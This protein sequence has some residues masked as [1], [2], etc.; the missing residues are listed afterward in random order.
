MMHVGSA[1]AHIFECPNKDCKSTFTK[2]VEINFSTRCDVCKT[3][4]PPIVFMV[5]N[6]AARLDY[7]LENAKREEIFRGEK[8]KRL[9]KAASSLAPLRNTLCQDALGSM[10]IDEMTLNMSMQ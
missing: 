9:G 6:K 3:N 8:N 2:Y 5:K 1:R 4:L 7:H 10:I